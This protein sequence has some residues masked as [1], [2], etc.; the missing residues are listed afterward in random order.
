[1]RIAVAFDHAG[2]PFTH[3]VAEA[4]R[5][6]GHEPV[7]V[8]TCDDYPDAALLAGQAIHSGEVERAVV[9]CG[10]GAGIAV[11]ATKLPGIRACVGHDTYTAAQCVTHDDC[12]VLCV[13]AR[14]IGPVYAAA[15][16]TAFA[17]ASFSGEE[18]HVRRLH[19]IDQLEQRG[20]ALE[21]PT[22]QEHT[23]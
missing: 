2:V 6:A 4:I 18:R 15:C 8:G 3:V 16:I 10:S 1:M 20:F 22:P 7:D 23:P 5:A 12:N 11:A 9:V 21:P 14:V 19:K 17:G 13:G